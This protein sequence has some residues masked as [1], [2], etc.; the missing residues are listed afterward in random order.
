MIEE[1]FPKIPEKNIKLA[2]LLMTIVMTVT[3]IICT[4]ILFSLNADAIKNPCDYCDC[5]KTVGGELINGR[6]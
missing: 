2:L 6:I 4:I 5:I 1:L 3:I